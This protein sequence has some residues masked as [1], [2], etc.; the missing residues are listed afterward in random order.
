M[1]IKLGDIKGESVDSKHKDEI[2]I[3]SW[4]WGVTS[5]Y[6]SHVSS[7][8]GAGAS[9]VNALVLTKYIDQS[10][11]IIFQNAVKGTL[12]KEA[13][14]VIQKVSGGSRPIEFI[15]IKLTDVFVTSVKPGGTNGDDRQKEEIMLQFGSA[16]YS[17][18]PVRSDGSPG[19]AVTVSWKTAR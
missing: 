19:A 18:I 3:L 9:T 16:E 5:A 8:A 10:S 13:T 1:L 14:F 15:K 6:S 12:I 11:P 7:G 17:Y 4:S 2:D